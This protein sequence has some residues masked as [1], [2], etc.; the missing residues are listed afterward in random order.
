MVWRTGARRW[1]VG[2]LAVMLA[3]CVGGGLAGGVASAEEVPVIRMAWGFDLHAGVLLVAA[4]RGEAFKDG[5]VYLKTVVDKQEYELFSGDKKLAVFQMVATKGSSESAVMLGQKQLDCCVNSIT[6]MMFAR[7]AGTPVRILCPVH[8]DGIGLVFPKGTEW[9]GWDELKRFILSADTPVRLGYHSPVSAPRVVLETALRESGLHVTEDPNEASADVLLVDLKGSRNLLTAFNGEQ[10]EGWVGPSH[11]PETAEFQGI[12]KV[13]LHLRDFPPQGQWYDFPCCT[14]AAREDA[15][16]A[17]PEVFQ[18][19]VTLLKH[20]A[21]WCEA[22]RG[23]AARVTA[24]VIGI[25]QEAAE[26]ATIV[27]T[28]TPTPKWHDGVK[29]YIKVM[30][31]LGKLEKDLKGKSYEEIAPV[32]FDFRFIENAR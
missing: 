13:V 21:T 31:D 30:N 20:S 24:E 1:M 15:I 11:Y 18:A 19:M 14:F 2:F 22:N 26:A 17:H 9:Y 28:T 27:F 6:G 32:F 23:E 12:G 16:E 8:V 7:D 3:G 10:V 29:L 5:G 25:P 4:S